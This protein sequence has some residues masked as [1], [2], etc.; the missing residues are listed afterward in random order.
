VSGEQAAQDSGAGDGGTQVVWDVVV[1]GAGPAVGEA[2]AGCRPAITDLGDP[3]G[4]GFSYADAVN[5]KGGS[6]MKLRM[7]LPLL[8]V[9]ALMLGVAT[10]TAGK[11]GNSANAKLCYKGGWQTLVRGDGSSFASQ[12]ECVSYAAQGG[13][14][15]PKPTSTC[16]AGSENFSGFT[17]GA[18]G[19][20]PTT[21]SGGTIDTSYG[22]AGGVWQQ[23]PSG[24][25]AGGF[26]DGTN[27]LFSGFDV[28]SFKLSFTNAV[29]SISL[30]EQ[31]N[32]TI[33]STTDTLTAFD[34]SDQ[35]IGSDSAGHA[36]GTTVNTLTVSSTSDNIAYFTIATDDSDGIG[37]SNIV[38][39]CN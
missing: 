6:V 24:I 37:F 5:S 19:D 2:S 29:A 36:A 30:D 38:W 39:G 27:L 22:T 34:A 12:D 4:G 11:G 16:T 3:L 10:A 20:T 32:T 1:I 14:L 7:V 26:A 31:P 8:G 33:N 17:A 13:T 28:T 25:W 15:Q 35:V 18:P 9:L 23:A 21:F